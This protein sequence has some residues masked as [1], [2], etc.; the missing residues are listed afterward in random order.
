MIRGL[1]TGA[2]GQLGRAVIAELEAASDFAEPVALTRAEADLTRAGALAS[3]I[4]TARPE[5]VFHCA[6]MTA[7]DRCESDAEEARAVNGRACE[8][9]AEAA[10]AV[11]ARVLGISTDYVFRGDDPAGYDEDSPTGP[12]SVYGQTKLAGEA[13][14]L[15]ADARNI[16]ARVS[17]LF[18]PGGANFVETM[19]R[20][21]E[22]G[23][24]LTVVTDQVG[25]PTYAPHLARSLLELARQPTGGLVHITGLGPT[26][27]WHAFAVE[28]MKQAGHAITI[29]ETTGAAFARP[30]P[31]PSC[32][33][34]NSVR[35]ERFGL[36]PQPDWR[37]GLS[38]FIRRR[39]ASAS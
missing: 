17:W 11:G 14:I 3:A 39:S 4:T 12:L 1:V 15:A 22:Q 5:V 30:A 16:V 13:P 38:D 27:S 23:R 21:A 19:L 35:A 37:E 34:L 7:V 29:G 28:I 2:G 20:F 31:R 6:A 18:G 8:E 32:S 10:Q 24:P 33:I 9:L 36:A 26:V 25:R